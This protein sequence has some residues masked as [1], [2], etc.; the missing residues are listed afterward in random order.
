[1]TQ[2]PESSLVNAVCATCGTTFTV[3]TTASSLSLDVCSN[4]HPA[5]T[6]L[7][8]QTAHGDRI[9]RFNRRRELALSR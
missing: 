7:E 8:R 6:G 9:D 1:M 5:Y 2:H 3:R 4:C